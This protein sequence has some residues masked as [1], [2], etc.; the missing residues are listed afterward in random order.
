MKKKGFTLIELLAVI[1]ILAIL[2]F[3]LIPII[4]DLIENARFASAVNSAMSYINEAN[5]QAT[6]EAGGFEEFSLNVQN[7]GI[8]ESGVNDSELNKI[9]YKGKGPTYAYL[10]FAKNGKYVKY[11]R[12]CIWGYSIE[13]RID[14]GAAKSNEDYC[15][16]NE[17]VVVPDHF[18]AGDAIY[19]NVDTGKQCSEQAYSNNV[20][21]W[22]QHAN[23]MSV[24]DKL[25]PRGV[26]E[27][28]DGLHTGCLK[29]YV[30][31]DNSDTI[32]L[33]TS[34]NIN[35]IGPDKDE[36]D[37][38]KYGFRNMYWADIKDGETKQNVKD[39]N[40]ITNPQTNT[41]YVMSLLK[42]YTNKW[43]TIPVE[44]DYEYSYT[45]N[46]GTDD[47]TDSYTVAYK[48]NDYK[49]RL[50]TKDEVDEV[51]TANKKD[52]LKDHTFQ[53]PYPYLM[54]GGTKYISIYGFYTSDAANASDIYV[55]TGG[56]EPLSTVDGT[57]STYKYGVRP[58]IE[59]YRDNLT[60]KEPTPEPVDIPDPGPSSPDP[61]DI[62]TPPNDCVDCGGENNSQFE[63]GN[64]LYFNVDTGK[65][66][67]K[68]ESDMNVSYR[69]TP[70]GVNSGCMKFYVLPNLVEKDTVSLMLDHPFSLTSVYWFK[71]ASDIYGSYAMLLPPIS[72][73]SDI[74]LNTST[75]KGVEVPNNYTMQ[76]VQGSTYQYYF[77]TVIPYKDLGLKAR[78]ITAE[79]IDAV[80]HKYPEY[81]DDYLTD[82]YYANY[83]KEYS[84]FNGMH[85]V[86]GSYSTCENVTAYNHATYNPDC[87]PFGTTGYKVAPLSWLLNDYGKGYSILTNEPAAEY[88]DLYDGMDAA[89]NDS[90][91]QGCF[92]TSSYAKSS[93]DSTGPWVTII[94]DGPR[95]ENSSA[96]RLYKAVIEVKKNKFTAVK[97][98]ADIEITLGGTANYSAPGTFSVLDP[99]IASVDSNG[100][101]TALKIGVTQVKAVDGG[102]TRYAKVV[103][104]KPA[105]T[106][107]SNVID[108]YYNPTTGLECTSSEYSCTDTSNCVPM[109]IIGETA[110]GNYL[111][112]YYKNDYAAPWS[113]KYAID[114]DVNAEAKYGVM[115]YNH[116]YQMIENSLN[117]TKD[118]V[119]DEYPKDYID[120]TTKEYV[121]PWGTSILYE[122]G[123]P[124]YPKARYIT[125]EDVAKVKEATHDNYAIAPNIY[126]MLNNVGNTTRILSGE[127]TNENDSS[128]PVVGR[129]ASYNGG[130]LV[131]YA[132]A[133]SKSRISN[134]SGQDTYNSTG[135]GI[136]LSNRTYVWTQSSDDGGSVEIKQETPSTCNADWCVDMY[137]AYP[138]TNGHVHL[139]GEPTVNGGR[140]EKDIYINLQY[141]CGQVDGCGNTTPACE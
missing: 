102:A 82:S 120:Y 14:T 95:W 79:E 72:L 49:A 108:I 12:F 84:Y 46:N 26:G 135:T 60:N 136:Q 55:A 3:I 73:L 89:L 33:L 137:Y 29:F 92:W 18:D 48:T 62:P 134:L 96:P 30:L 124:V 131:N 40:N 76:A 128:T 103:V 28:P 70:V 77:R 54:D 34:F 98:D 5:T 8:L 11:A 59:I 123:N 31:K 81:D 93:K 7:D 6:I 129:L 41:Y 139:V 53:H 22:S 45:Y 19:Y 94:C 57:T 75:W 39:F 64:V 32:T 117:R 42:D 86:I 27:M 91:Y 104:N 74:A 47:I 67:T 51:V 50:I 107:Y 52:I 87:N 116:W 13:Y 24:G 35:E 80:L 65:Q 127:N 58:V 21:E 4:Q 90:S 121:I 119:V 114:T 63:P 115:A 105:N 118:W 88:V 68:G 69:H 106:Y 23:Y 133:I 125:L 1:I 138:K 130:N 126:E 15:K 112:Y 122:N 78:L 17:K 141:S 25:Y 38:S 56:W 43:V 109:K 66:C 61:T 16:T 132:L 83:N 100:R 97:K 10:H 113:G 111:V 37:A 101:I 9:K 85:S 2:A 36:T 110:L 71:E 44:N 140:S 20:Y 99:T